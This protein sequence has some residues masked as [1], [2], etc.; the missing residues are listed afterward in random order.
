MTNF[1]N[2][3]SVFQNFSWLRTWEWSEL[4]LWSDRYKCG[5]GFDVRNS[6]WSLITHPLVLYISCYNMLWFLS[7]RTYARE[8]QM[9]FSGFEW[10]KVIHFW[11][12]RI[13]SI[14]QTF[15]KRKW[16]SIPTKLKQE[17][18]LSRGT[19]RAIRTQLRYLLRI[20]WAWYQE[21][22]QSQM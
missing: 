5:Y 21:T 4:P 6:M 15:I 22:R 8:V 9:T 7:S 13:S 20:F 10:K 14:F 2:I 1:K 16:I 19:P 18:T 12:I 11:K 3:F 17:P